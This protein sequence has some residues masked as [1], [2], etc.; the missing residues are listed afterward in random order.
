MF[1]ALK[2]CCAKLVQYHLKHWKWVL[3]FTFLGDANC[4]FQSIAWTCCRFT[5]VCLLDQTEKSVRALM[6]SANWKLLRAKT[7]FR[8]LF[9]CHCFWLSARRDSHLCSKKICCKRIKCLKVPSSFYWL[10]VEIQT[11]ICVCLCHFTEVE[12]RLSLIIFHLFYCS[13]YCCNKQLFLV[14]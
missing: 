4:T 3:R 12:R 9:F 13:Q 14:D 2:G 11:L 5:N 7:D 10:K 1:D 6:D 8:F